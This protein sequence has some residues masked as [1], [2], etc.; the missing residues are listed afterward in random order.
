ME[1][2]TAAPDSI[3][4]FGFISF[5]W[6]DVLGVLHLI[7]PYADQ[8][9]PYHRRRGNPTTNIILV[10]PAR[11]TNHVV[12]CLVKQ[13][14]LR[15]VVVLLLAS[16]IPS[17]SSFISTSLSNTVLCDLHDSIRFDS[18]YHSS[19]IILTNW[20]GKSR[21]SAGILLLPKFYTLSWIWFSPTT[22]TVLSLESTREEKSTKRR[23]YHHQQ[24]NND[25]S[26]TISPI[27]LFVVFCC[28]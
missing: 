6:W 8:P 20:R 1:F 5:C 21:S 16:S 14:V 2:C 28:R 3:V 12:W 17:V 27:Y 18:I 23:Q 22:F 11:N 9:S 19:H 10:D 4:R 7:K 25:D 15:V 24:E 26:I 13:P